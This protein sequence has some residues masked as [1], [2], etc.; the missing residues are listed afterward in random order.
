MYTIMQIFVCVCV[1]VCVR[2]CVRAHTKIS[3]MQIYGCKISR[4]LSVI[5]HL[6]ITLL[7]A[8]ST[9][10]KLVLLAVDFSICDKIFL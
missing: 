6:A 1:C 7:L 8:Y 5:T 3:T 10:A 9:T 2:A 4:S